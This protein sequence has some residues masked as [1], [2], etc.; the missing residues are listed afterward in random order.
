MG[1]RPHGVRT[2]EL[3][4]RVRTAWAQ[5]QAP[6]VGCPGAARLLRIKPTSGAWRGSSINT[7]TCYRDGRTGTVA[8]S[9]GLAPVQDVIRGRTLTP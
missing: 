3:A 6:V 4:V 9:G 7:P 2:E 8:Y 5:R 1:I